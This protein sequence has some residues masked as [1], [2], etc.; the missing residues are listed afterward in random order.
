[1]SVSLRRTAK[2]TTIRARGADAWRL[3]EALA[4]CMAEPEAAKPPADTPEGVPNRSNSPPGTTA[5]GAAARPAKARR[6]EPT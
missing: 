6:S 5:A 3:L 2:G 1:M 4:S